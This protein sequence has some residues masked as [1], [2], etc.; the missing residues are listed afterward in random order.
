[1]LLLTAAWVG[2]LDPVFI[3]II[4]IILVLICSVYGIRFYGL[5]TNRLV[6]DYLV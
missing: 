5:V 1:M 3:V 4:A 6:E 2:R